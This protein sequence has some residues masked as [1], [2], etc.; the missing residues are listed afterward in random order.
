MKST[1]D[2]RIFTMNNNFYNCDEKR[3]FSVY[4][5]TS[6]I[7][8]SKWRE[9]VVGFELFTKVKFLNIF[10]PSRKKGSS[11]FEGHHPPQR[12]HQFGMEKNY[13][14]YLFDFEAYLVDVLKKLDSRFIN[15]ERNLVISS[16]I[17][18]ISASK[19][20]RMLLNSLSMTLK[21]PNLIG[22]LCLRP[23]SDICTVHWTSNRGKKNEN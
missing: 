22:I 15:S 11:N 21:S 8:F 16:S 20:S 6:T 5:N 12:E 3:Y 14:I 9:E 7:H 2:I 23:L 18:R 17:L 13:I 19:R 10:I 4:I 1:T